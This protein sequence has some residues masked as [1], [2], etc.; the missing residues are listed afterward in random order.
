MTAKVAFYAPL[1][2]PYHHIPSGDREIARLMMRALRLAAYEVD[3][4]S[5]VISYQ[6]R[7][8]ID[9]YDTRH[10]AVLAEEQRIRSLWNSDPDSR[11]DVWFTYHPYCKSP[12]W[13][14]PPL[15]KR[16]G[17][18]Y[19]TAEACRTHQGQDSDW[20]RG[21]SAVQAAVRAA[22]ANFVLKD[23]D[24]DYLETF[25]P[26]MDSAVRIPPFLDLASQPRTPTLDPRVVFEAD[27]PLLFAAGMMR[28]GAKKE[29]YRLLATALAG[30]DHRNWNLIVAGDG[31]E[32][33]FV[34][35][36]FGFLEPD[37]VVFLGS[38]EHDDMF[39]L[40]DRADLFVWP[41]IGEAIGQVYLEAQSRGL[42]VVAMSTAGVPLVVSNDVGG[43]LTADGD[44]VAYG[45]EID[46][47]LDN[48]GRLAGLAAGA[49]EYVRSSHDVQAVASTFRLIL[50]PIIQPSSG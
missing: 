22:D 32:R 26:M 28:P 43:I 15:C 36:Q 25:M 40:M 30:L 44:V 47:L 37:R 13:L 46:G 24:W 12:D 35:S 49:A 19:V 33:S 6:K 5:E 14:G 39:A 21:R 29:S 42:P 16:F 50:D 41:G 18:P 27:Q 3:L 34:E 4:I 11:P 17:I 2:S 48:P 45:S 10:A 1:K 9:L 7:P 23:T 38:V 31:P 8:S 20:A